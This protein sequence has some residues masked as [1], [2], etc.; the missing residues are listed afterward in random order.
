[1]MDGLSIKVKMK[2][3]FEKTYELSAKVIVGYEYKYKQGFPKLF[4]DMKYEHLCWLAWKS[5]YLDGVVVQPFSPP[6]QPGF[7]DDLFD[8]ELVDDPS[9]KS[10]ATP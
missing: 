3:G 1:M 10:T 6:D 8:V 4:E 7:L 9:L 5:M 2:D